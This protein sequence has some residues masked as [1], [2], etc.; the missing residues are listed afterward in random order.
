MSAPKSHRL[1]IKSRRSGDK[2]PR[3][4][5]VRLSAKLQIKLGHV[6]TELARRISARAEAKKR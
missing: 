5:R 1:R 2:C 3:Y 4:R 6:A